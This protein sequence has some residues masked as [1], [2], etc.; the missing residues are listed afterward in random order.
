M[1]FVLEV[2]RVDF[3]DWTLDFLEWVGVFDGVEVL[4]SR[5]IIFYVGDGEAW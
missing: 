1:G 5:G 3:V 2:A 4:L